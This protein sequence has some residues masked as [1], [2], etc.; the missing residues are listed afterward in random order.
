MKTKM[1]LIALL[2]VS[3]LSPS[4]LGQE[5]FRGGIVYGPKAAFK[6]DAPDAWVLDNKS[7]VKQGLP[8]VLYPKGSSWAD[9]KTIM[10]AKIASTEFEDVNEFVAWAIK[11]M[12]AKHG[13]PKQK[14]ASGKTQDGRDYFINEYP[15][16]K[17]YSQWERVGYVQLPRAV[18]YIVLSSRDK[19]NYSKDAPALDK[20]IAKKTYAFVKK[21]S[22][23]ENGAGELSLQIKQVS[24]DGMI[25]LDASEQCRFGDCRGETI[26]KVNERLRLSDEPNGPRLEIQKMRR[27]PND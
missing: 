11:G 5:T 9:A 4:M 22:D 27:L 16:T 24:N 23:S 25:D 2:V 10:Y 19:T 8:C 21:R 14:I 6:I 7:G 26:F 20:A 3:T 15:A 18:A 1:Y 13:T 17:T 12:K